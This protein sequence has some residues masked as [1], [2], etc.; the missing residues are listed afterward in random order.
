MQIDGL[1]HDRMAFMYS[2]RLKCVRSLLD[3]ADAQ[4]KA[5]L[6]DTEKTIEEHILILNKFSS[7]MIPVDFFKTLSSALLRSEIGR[8]VN[9]EV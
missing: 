4:R 3:G 8:V 7:C 1:D 2:L 5:V 6:R 9:K